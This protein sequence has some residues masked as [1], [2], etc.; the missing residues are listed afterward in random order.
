MPPDKYQL[1]YELEKEIEQRLRKGAYVTNEA[2]QITA[3]HLDNLKLS[4]FPQSILKFRNL[5]ALS[6]ANNQLSSIP[7]DIQDLRHLVRINL[8]GNQL[9]SLPSAIGELTELRILSLNRN[10]L[11]HIPETIAD[12]KKLRELHLAENAL[13]ELPYRLSELKSLQI[14][15]LGEN[16]ISKLPAEFR[17]LEIPFKWTYDFQDFG[18]YLEGNPL[19]SPPASMVKEENQNEIRYHLE[20][21]ELSAVVN[22]ELKCCIVGPAGSGKSSFRN[23][24]TD[25]AFDMLPPSTEGIDFDQV[26]I[27]KDESEVDLR[28][29]DFSGAPRHLS[30]QSSFFTGRSIYFIVLEPERYSELETWLDRFS[31]IPGAMR[32]FL[33]INKTDLSPLFDLDR[34]HLSKKYPFISA[35][36]T[37]SLMQNSGLEPIIP[38]LFRH[39]HTFDMYKLNIPVNWMKVMQQVSQST[40]PF[41]SIETLSPLFLSFGVNK[42]EDQESLL[43]LLE[44]Q[45]FISYLKEEPELIFINEWLIRSLTLFYNSEPL[46]ARDGILSGEELDL[47][48]DS[49]LEEQSQR[50][51]LIRFLLEKKLAWRDEAFNLYLP[52]CFTRNE[53]EFEF[54]FEKKAIS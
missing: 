18:L 12:L 23:Y 13:R 44:D 24:L 14:I 9:S 1:I 51:A 2:D 34:E 31:L 29:W 17:E 32:L 15:D 45:G 42:L 39:I 47:L 52:D 48:L 50:E 21:A 43:E 53:P 19:I 46:R 26:K 8:N 7:S 27:Q 5:Y 28:I 36:Y 40:E 20:N 16:Q 22:K 4:T 35:I 33:I 30:W 37:I 10:K 11:E 38:A 6:L 49:L 25:K 41:F 54:D 3:L